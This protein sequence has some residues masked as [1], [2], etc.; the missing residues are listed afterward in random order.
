MNDLRFNAKDLLYI[1]VGSGPALFFSWLNPQCD[2]P[3]F[4]LGG[5]FLL[6]FIHCLIVFWLAA[7]LKES[8]RLLLAAAEFAVM[9][10]VFL[11]CCLLL[12]FNAGIRTTV[13]VYLFC[14]FGYGLTGSALALYYTDF[15]DTKEEN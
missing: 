9:G 11:L 1:L 3:G 8:F 7:D 4:I 14:L 6:W 10:V 5:F 2:P 15:H 12:L 13:Y